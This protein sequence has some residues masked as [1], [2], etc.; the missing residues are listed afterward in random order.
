M[1]PQTSNIRSYVAFI[2]I[3]VRHIDL[4]QIAD[5]E[6]KISV[7]YDM[8]DE[9]DATNRDAKGLP[10]TVRFFFFHHVVSI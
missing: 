4:A 5:E 10:F 7:L 6:R 9:Q 2:I 1:G 3:S 8:L